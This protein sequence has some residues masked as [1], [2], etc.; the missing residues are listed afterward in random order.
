VFL[1]GFG[2]TQVKYDYAPLMVGG[3]VL[4]GLGLLSVVGAW[5]SRQGEVRGRDVARVFT[6]LLALIGFL[7]VGALV[8]FVAAAIVLLSTCLVR[9]R[10]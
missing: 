10:F 9:G 8:L 1:L 2:I 5:V 3:N 4:L 6:K 7:I